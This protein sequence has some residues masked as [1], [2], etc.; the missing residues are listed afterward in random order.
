LV[1]LLLAQGSSFD[2]M[3]FLP[4]PLT[5]MV[6]VG[7]EPRFAWCKSIALTTA[8]PYSATHQVGSELKLEITRKFNIEMYNQDNV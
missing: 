3:P 7:V 5:C 1:G 8:A 6:P 2:R 4:S